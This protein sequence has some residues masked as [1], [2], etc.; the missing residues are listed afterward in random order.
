MGVGGDLDLHNSTECESEMCF[1][2]RKSLAAQSG[3]C[4][5]KKLSLP[6]K[7]ADV[8][9]PEDQKASYTTANFLA[10]KVAYA[11]LAAP[12]SA[13]SAFSKARRRIFSTAAAARAS[14][15]SHALRTSLADAVAP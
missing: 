14:P 3:A 8:H 5:R 13:A 1:A 7:R 9:Q 4:S 11:W 12:F 6:A 10:A 2:E 15:P